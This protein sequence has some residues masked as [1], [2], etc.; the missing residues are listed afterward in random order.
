MIRRPPRSTLFPY[1]TLFR[2]FHQYSLFIGE[3]FE[4]RSALP[5]GKELDE[6]VHRHL[7]QLVDRVPAIS[8]L[9]RRSSSPVLRH[10]SST[11]KIRMF[12]GSIAPSDALPVRSGERRCCR[13]FFQEVYRDRQS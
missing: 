9:S 4:E 12:L 13:L 6:L 7:L 8:E 11:C 3:A 10:A 1:T 5:S 2:S